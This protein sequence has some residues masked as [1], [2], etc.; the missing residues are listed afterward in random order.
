MKQHSIAWLNGQTMNDDLLTG[1]TWNP[2]TGCDER[3]ISPGCDHCYARAFA[4]RKLW[5]YDFTP[6]LHPDRLNQPS[7]WK[8]PRVIFVCSMGD[9]FCDGVKREW[10]REVYSAIASAPHHRYI[11]LT[12]RP[13][14]AA[15]WHMDRSNV[16]LGVSVENNDYA[17]RIDTLCNIDCAGVKFVSHEPALGPIDWQDRWF[18]PGGIGWVIVGGETGPGARAMSRGTFPAAHVACQ[19]NGVPLYLK[20]WG[21]GGQVGNWNGQIQES[22]RRFPKA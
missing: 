8:K 1:E 3:G 2:V 16:W 12:K 10:V 6:R 4:A 20:G 22:E 7:R 19:E 15:T 18:G 14:N 17:H 5:R 13:D 11:F 9:L 21:T